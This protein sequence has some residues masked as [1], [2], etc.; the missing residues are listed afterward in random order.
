MA[1]NADEMILSIL[2]KTCIMCYDAGPLNPPQKVCCQFKSGR[3][4]LFG[5]RS[6]K[7]FVR[8]YHRKGKPSEHRKRPE[9]VLVLRTQGG[10]EK[11]SKLRRSLLESNVQYVCSGCSIEGV[12]NGEKLVL[13]IDHKNGNWL[14][15]RLENLQFLCPNC[16]SQKT[17]KT[18]DTP[19]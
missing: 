18:K 19:G 5:S 7:Q 2:S 8:I 15:D 12:W 6:I 14:D 17:N 9:E 3:I 4:L 11:T 10:R 1:L 16:H 13:E